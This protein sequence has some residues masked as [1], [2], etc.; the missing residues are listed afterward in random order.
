LH[1]HERLPI[2]VYQ[3][4]GKKIGL[5]LTS[6][7]QR[8]ELRFTFSPPALVW[9]ALNTTAAKNGLVRGLRPSHRVPRAYSGSSI[10]AAP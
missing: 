6:R 10:A 4:E 8:D 9:L 7:T 1:N 3:G 5:S 2:V